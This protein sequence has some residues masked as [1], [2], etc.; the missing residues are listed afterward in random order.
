MRIVDMAIVL[1][2]T[3]AIRQQL[4]RN[5]GVNFLARSPAVN[6]AALKVDNA[7]LP[8]GQMARLLAGAKAQALSAL[9]PNHLVIGADQ[10]LSCQGK[11][12]DKPQSL[13]LA[14]EQ[15]L[16]LR[17]QTHELVSAVCCARNGTMLWEL[18]DCAHL[19]MRDFSVN[20]VDSYLTRI[21]TDAMTSVGAYKLEGT[22]LQLFS[23]IEGNYFTILGLPLLPLLEYLRSAG[24]IPT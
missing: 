8:T 14:R 20:F 24:E 6:E 18:Q 7:G 17:G 10:I 11:A 3:S 13:A 15:L 23:R 19:T 16:A 4:L 12:H 1:A 21:G 22:G 2:S 9:M 5:A